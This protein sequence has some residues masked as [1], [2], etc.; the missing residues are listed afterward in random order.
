MVLEEFII[1]RKA[2]TINIRLIVAPDLDDHNG[3][4]FW[5]YNF[6]KKRL[7]KQAANAIYKNLQKKISPAK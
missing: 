7:V 5:G 2:I 4:F 1:T 3:I 6:K